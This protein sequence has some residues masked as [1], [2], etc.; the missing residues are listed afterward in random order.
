[1]PLANNAASLEAALHS[2]L[3]KRTVDGKIGICAPSVIDYSPCNYRMSS[4]I[5]QEASLKKKRAF[6]FWGGGNG[7]MM[8]RLSMRT[9][10]FFLFFL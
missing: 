7:I 3:L 4:K 6:C 10:M 9:K 2:A 1:M 5:S 8:L